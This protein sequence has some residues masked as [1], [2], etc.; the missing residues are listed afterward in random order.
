MFLTVLDLLCYAGIFVWMF[1]DV[2]SELRNK[3][4]QKIW[5]KKKA[6]IIQIDLAITQAELCKKYV[7]FCKKNK[8][9]VDF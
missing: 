7:D 1:I 3:K 9:L 4:Y 6:D 5:N 2:T 8:C